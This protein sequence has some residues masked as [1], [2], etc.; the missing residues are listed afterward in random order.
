MIPPVFP[1]PGCLSE[2]TASGTVSIN[3]VSF[4]VFQCGTCVR[5]VVLFGEPFDVALTF[6]VDEDGVAFDPA[7]DALGIPENN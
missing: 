3:P 5:P 2:L 1:C 4:P 6:A 7:S